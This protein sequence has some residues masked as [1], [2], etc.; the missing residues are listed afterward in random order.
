MQKIMKTRILIHYVEGWLIVFPCVILMETVKEAIIMGC[1]VYALLIRL[2][3]IVIDWI[4]TK[5]ISTFNALELGFIL[6]IW[7]IMYWDVT[8]TEDR[9]EEKKNVKQQ[10]QTV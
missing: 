3:W 9:Y 7:F 8:R 2:T 6:G 1:I 4:K 10:E 5:K